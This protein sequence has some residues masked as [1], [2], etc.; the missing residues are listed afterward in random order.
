MVVSCGSYPARCDGVFYWLIIFFE[1]QILF[2]FFIF[3]IVTKINKSRENDIIF[4]SEA[5]NNHVPSLKPNF[6]ISK[7]STKGNT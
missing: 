1:K 3:E 2:L 6:S 7:K 5:E 4:L